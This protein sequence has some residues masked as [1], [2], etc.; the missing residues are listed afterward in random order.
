VQKIVP[1]V[2]RHNILWIEVDV[3]GMGY[4]KDDLKGKRG[5]HQ[6]NDRQMKFNLFAVPSG[7]AQGTLASLQCRLERY[8]WS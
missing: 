6:T 8:L 5:G 3:W 4:L 1:K 7:V 2:P